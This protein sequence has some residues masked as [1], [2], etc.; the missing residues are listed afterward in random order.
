MVA[1]TNGASNV[2][3]INYIDQSVQAGLTFGY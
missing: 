2:T 1:G 3:N